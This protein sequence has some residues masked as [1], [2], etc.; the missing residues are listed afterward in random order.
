MSEYLVVF[1]HEGESRGA[2]YPDLPGVGV[3]GETREEAEKLIREA[4][5]LHLDGLHQAGEP[6]PAPSAVGATLVEAPGA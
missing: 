3:V 5:A 4:S 6:L 1:E 2:S